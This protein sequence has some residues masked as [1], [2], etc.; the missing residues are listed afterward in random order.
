M[1]TV[2]YSLI[3]RE[4]VDRFGDDYDTLQATEQT[5]FRGFFSKRLRKAYEEEWW[6]D[7]MR[8]EKRFFRDDYAAA[9]AYTAGTEVYLPDS[10]KYYQAVQA[11][12]GNAP[13][14]GSP[15]ATNLQYWADSATSYS[16]SNWA[17][18]KAYIRGDQVWYPQKNKFYQCHTAHTSSSTLTPD[19][20]GGNNRW[21]ALTEFDRYAGYNQTGKTSL[22]DVTVAMVWDKNPKLYRDAKE[23]DWF[24]SANGVQV[25]SSVTKCW[26]EFRVRPPILKGDK[27]DAA[28][29]YAIDEQ[30]RFDNSGISNFYDCLAATTAG[31]SPVS[32]AA[33]WQIVQIPAFLHQYLVQGAYAEALKAE[34]LSD[35]ADD[36]NFVAEAILSEQVGKLR[37][38]QPTR[39]IVKSR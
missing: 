27:F 14:T 4:A 31:E 26:V 22:D 28:K 37:G 10:D 11:T 2:D 18:G 3:L 33:K 12:T 36:E 8:T 19:A 16:A 13:A 24:L 5:R 38:Q 7:L 20:T 29:A 35:K 15:L 17:S 1:R 39:T 25:R 34:G 21:G 23:L 9:T 6:P 32:A 30:I